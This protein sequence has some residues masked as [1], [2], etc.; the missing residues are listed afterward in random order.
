MR[1]IQNSPP[2]SYQFPT[3]KVRTKFRSVCIAILPSSQVH[4]SFQTSTKHI[5]ALRRRRRRRRRR[6]RRRRRRRCRCRRRC[7]HCRRRCRCRCPSSRLMSTVRCFV[8]VR[9]FCNF[10]INTQCGSV[11]SIVRFIGITVLSIMSCGCGL[12]TTQPT[13]TFAVVQPR[14]TNNERR[15]TNDERRTTNNERR[16]TNETTTT[17]RW[18]ARSVVP[19]RKDIFGKKGVMK[20]LAAAGCLSG[21]A[22][23]G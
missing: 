2:K 3:L 17:R 12:A 18:S 13:N 1:G 9:Q 10:V 21:H 19:P 7:R 14:T 15:T 16:T 8:I 5:P 11:S 4:N 23:G 6:C 20:V 22:G